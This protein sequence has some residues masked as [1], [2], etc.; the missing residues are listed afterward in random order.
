MS[1]LCRLIST[2]LRR[3]PRQFKA[4]RALTIAGRDQQLRQGQAVIESSA[5]DI[6]EVGLRQD[7]ADIAAKW[8]I[9]RR[10]PVASSRV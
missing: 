2:K 5:G 4:E 8:S 9:Q 1:A 3:S 7:G 10:L 6:D